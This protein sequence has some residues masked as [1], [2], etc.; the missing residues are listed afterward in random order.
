MNNERKL[1]KSFTEVSGGN[2]PITIAGEAV[3]KRTGRPSIDEMYKELDNQTGNQA[4]GTSTQNPSQD[5]VTEQDRQMFRET[6][7]SVTVLIDV[8][9]V[10]IFQNQM[11]SL[12]YSKND[13]VEFCA[14]IPMKPELREQFV[15]SG[16]VLAEKYGFIKIGPE[17]AFVG[18]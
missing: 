16:T 1:E 6:A 17:A 8:L 5:V 3:K 10:T 7:K 13:T 9:A 11:S 14:Q 15:S 18:A 2:D 4:G 12:S